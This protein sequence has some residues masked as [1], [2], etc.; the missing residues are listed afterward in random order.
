MHRRRVHSL[1]GDDLAAGTDA[2]ATNAQ[3]TLHRGA[4]L[5]GYVQAFSNRMG[6]A[7]APQFRFRLAMRFTDHELVMRLD[8]SFPEIALARPQATATTSAICLS[9]DSHGRTPRR[10]YSAPLSSIGL[11]SQPRISLDWRQPRGWW[12]W[13]LQG[14]SWEGP[15]ENTAPI[16]ERHP[17]VH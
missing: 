9:L 4:F 1:A 8:S 5:T 14:A 6:R 10:S 7:R 11:G 12:L 3:C 13:A 16:Q 17:L 2:K 15:P